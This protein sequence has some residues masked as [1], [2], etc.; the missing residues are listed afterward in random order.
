MR[1]IQVYHARHGPFAPYPRAWHTYDIY[2]RFTSEWPTAMW[3]WSPPLF[4]FHQ[5]K[6]FFP[7]ASFSGSMHFTESWRL[8]LWDWTTTQQTTGYISHSLTVFEWWS[9][10]VKTVCFPWEGSIVTSRV[11]G[12][13][14]SIVSEVVSCILYQ[15]QSRPIKIG[16]K[17]QNG[18]SLE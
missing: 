6:N 1:S 14:V 9:T 13:S 3:Q 5:C 17:S 16:G 18:S 4:R 15:T 2:Q 10:T 8:F 12:G 11:E 7:T